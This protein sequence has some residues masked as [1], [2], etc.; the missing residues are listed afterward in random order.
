[1]CGET[2]GDIPLVV[3]EEIE[4]VVYRGLLN[5]HRLVSPHMG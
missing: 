4:H 3:F 5:E 1:M 2:L